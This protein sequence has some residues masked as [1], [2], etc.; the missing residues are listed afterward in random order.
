MKLK[1][2][3]KEDPEYLESKIASLKT[4]HG[5]QIGEDLKVAA[6]V[7]AG[8]H[9]YSDTICSKT[10]AIKRAGG[11]VTSADLIQTMM[12]SFRIYRKV[13]SDTSDSKDK[14]NVTTT[15]FKYDCNLC[16]KG[17][18]KAMDCPQHDKVKCKHCG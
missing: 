2:K 3:N 9:Q 5:C 6:I 8:G 16:G 10:K 17:R 18:H 14:V 13:D 15:S 7:K 11:N 4:N 12:E 1:L